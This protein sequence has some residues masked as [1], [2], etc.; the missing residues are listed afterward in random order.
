MRRSM[1][2]IRGLAQAPAELTLVLR[3]E[4]VTLTE[5]AK[6]LL[7]LTLGADKERIVQGGAALLSAAKWTKD[8]VAIERESEVGGGIKDKISLNEAGDL[9]LERE[10]DLMGRSVK[11]TMIYR[12]KPG[13][14]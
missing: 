8:G 3:P 6:N 12:R 9:V 7:I 1:E 2:A 13:G 14:H 11:G 5:D 4:N 10:I